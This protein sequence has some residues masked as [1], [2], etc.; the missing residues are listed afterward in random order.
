MQPSTEQ[1]RKPLSQQTHEPLAFLGRELNGGERSW[2]TY[3]K[4][5]F[6]VFKVFE[7]LDFMVMGEHHIYAFTDHRNHFFVFAPCTL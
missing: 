4:E 6:A 5:G 2:T 7:M 1:L 3:E